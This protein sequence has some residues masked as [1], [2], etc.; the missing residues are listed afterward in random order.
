TDRLFLRCLLRGVDL[1]QSPLGPQADGARA[2]G[3]NRAR[4]IHHGRG[5]RVL[6]RD[7]L[8]QPANAH[9]HE[10]QE[11][12]KKETRLYV[13]CIIALVTMAFGFVVRAFLITDWGVRFNLSETQIG[14]IKGS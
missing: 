12:M 4:A 3:E 6:A 8:R 14:S 10:A 7:S 9:R 13:A 11:T 1:R 5:A 2:G